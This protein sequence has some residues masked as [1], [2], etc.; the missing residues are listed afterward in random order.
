[1]DN[2]RA[3]SIYTI[4]GKHRDIAPVRR[5]KK[6]REESEKVNRDVIFRREIVLAWAGLAYTLCGQV[7]PSGCKKDSRIRVADEEKG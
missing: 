2:G 5:E 1:M 7:M 6:V 4:F 3:S